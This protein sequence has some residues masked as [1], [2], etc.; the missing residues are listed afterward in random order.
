ML[1]ERIAKQSRTNPLE[2]ALELSG[3]LRID[4]FGTCKRI[5]DAINFV[6]RLDHAVEHIFRF[7]LHAFGVFV[8]TI[9]VDQSGVLNADGKVKP[10]LYGVQVNLVAQNVAVD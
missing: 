5:G 3:I 6:L 4:H 8:D 7:A 10:A 9:T 2:A 1:G